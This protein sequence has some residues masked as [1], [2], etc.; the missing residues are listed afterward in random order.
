M[1]FWIALLGCVVLAVIVMVWALETVQDARPAH[2][3]PSD[4]DKV[5]TEKDDDFARRRTLSGAT[6]SRTASHTEFTRRSQ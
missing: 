5:A 6:H 1:L 4:W 3:S 2:V